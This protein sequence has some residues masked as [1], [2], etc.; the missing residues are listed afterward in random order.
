[1]VRRLP[2]PPNAAPLPH[3]MQI[4]ALNHVVAESHFCYFVSQLK[5]VTKSSG[6][7]VF[8]GQQFE[9]SLL[10]LKNFGPWLRGDSGRGP[11]N[12][13]RTVSTR[14]TT[15]GALTRVYVP[16]GTPASRSFCSFSQT[17]LSKLHS[18]ER[19]QKQNWRKKK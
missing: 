14:P 11:K 9:T 7:I 3:R 17:R 10:W 15:A 18:T 2:A 8:C 12:T 5:K 6:E 1:M 4:F 16:K 19:D 13:A